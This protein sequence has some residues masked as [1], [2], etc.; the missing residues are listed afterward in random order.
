[1]TPERELTRFASAEL[2]RSTHPELAKKVMKVQIARSPEPILLL[3]SGIFQVKR[4][5]GELDS[6]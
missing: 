6:D 2:L 1:M 3:R 5:H 4:Y